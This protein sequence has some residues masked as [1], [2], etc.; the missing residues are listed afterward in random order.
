MKPIR[1]LSATLAVLLTLSLLVSCTEKKRAVMTCAGFSVTE[2]MYNYYYAAYKYLY[3]VENKGFSDDESGWTRQNGS[4]TYEEDFHAFLTDRLT[5][6]MIAAYLYE[7]SGK[8][9]SS[10]QINKILQSVIETTFFYTEADSKKEYS[11]LLAPYGADYEDMLRCLLFEYEYDLLYAGLFGQ[12]GTG[13]L[14]DPA[15]KEDVKAFYDETYIRIRYMTVDTDDIR[16]E[17]KKTAFLAANS[18]AAFDTMLKGYATNEST[19]AFFYLYGNY[20]VEKALLD[21]VGKLAVGENA[22][23]T[24]SDGTVCYLRRYA[25]NKEYEEE[26]YADYFKD[27]APRAAGHAYRNYLYSFQDKVA[28]HEIPAYRPWE[29]KTCIEENVIDIYQG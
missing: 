17:E 24:L 4:E 19:D 6:R 21:A 22:S 18:D 16:K 13:V 7:T 25:T 28:T 14:T 9:E 26:A 10:S 29:R 8:G 27:F 15:F 11:A 23:V 20:T 1:L 2:G 3:R 5:T 12:G